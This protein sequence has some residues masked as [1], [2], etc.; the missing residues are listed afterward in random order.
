MDIIRKSSCSY[1]ESPDLYEDEWDSRFKL[2][3]FGRQGFVAMTPEQYIKLRE[4]VPEEILFCYILRL[5]EEIGNGIR[6]H[7][8][9]KTLKKWITEDLST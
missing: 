4:M 6:T 7:S 1:K 2:V 3:S 9:Y 8:N 5:E